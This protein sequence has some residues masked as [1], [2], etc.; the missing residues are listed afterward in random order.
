MGSL[1]SGPVTALLIAVFLLIDLKPDWVRGG[2]AGA[3]G[4]LTMCLVLDRNR[5]KVLQTILEGEQRCTKC[6]YDLKSH[7]GGSCPE[8][9]EQITQS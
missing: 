3:V 6:G 5:K 9:G 4:G 1:I 8:C 7:S 2:I